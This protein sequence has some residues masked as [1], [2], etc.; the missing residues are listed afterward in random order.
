MKD[1]MRC[2]DV[3]IKNGCY[4]V[5]VTM[6][7]L[8]RHR[9]VDA[10]EWGIPPEEFDAESAVVLLRYSRKAFDMEEYKDTMRRKIVIDE[11]NALFDTTARYIELKPEM[12][13][14]LMQLTKV[15]KK[16]SDV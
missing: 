3:Q 7:R 16:D 4:A 8:E 6:F 13:G 15:E 9:F 2:I 10:L 1:W 12:E 14:S 5:L 11:W